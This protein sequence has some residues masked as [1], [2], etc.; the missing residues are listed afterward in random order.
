MSCRAGRHPAAAGKT[1]VLVGV[2]CAS[3]SKSSLV[4]ECC[5]FRGI[6][7]LADTLRPEAR[8]AV[9]SLRA[10]GIEH[11]VM[12]TGDS[13]AVA[14]AI[15]S[16]LGV[17]YRAELLPEDKVTVVR[18]LAERYGDVI[19]VGDGV[20]DAP[21]LA[22]ATVGMAMGVGGTD[23]ALETADVVLMASDLSKVTYAIKLSRWAN[24]VVRQNLAFAIG[25]IITLV[26]SNLVGV[27]PLPIGVVGHEGS[28]LVVVL[29][30]LRLLGG[31][32]RIE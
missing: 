19:M 24:R 10:I 11:I 8:A 4:S 28:T 13:E 3:G 27:L 25:V 17:E 12:L 23:V 31:R 32:Q 29:N 26:L 22:A 20:N 2:R 21:A 1:A 30:G 16:Q 9:A 7:A 14:R 15:A 18:E 5:E 6:I